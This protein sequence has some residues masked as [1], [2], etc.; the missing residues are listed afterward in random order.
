MVKTIIFRLKRCTSRNLVTQIDET[1][2]EVSE[3][4]TSIQC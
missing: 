4:I 3:K 1:T 2:K